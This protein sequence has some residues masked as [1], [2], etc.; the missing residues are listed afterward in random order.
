MRRRLRAFCK[1]NGL[2]LEG[3]R[4][5]WQSIF[6]N[7]RLV[8]RQFEDED[9]FLP[10]VMML[11]EAEAIGLDALCCF[12]CWCLRIEDE[13]YRTQIYTQTGRRRSRR[14][15]AAGRIVAVVSVPIDQAVR[16]YHCAVGGAAAAR[17]EKAPAN[18]RAVKFCCNQAATR[19]AQSL[20]TAVP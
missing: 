8:I 16:C 1:A 12:L 18:A 2:T 15:V 17:K 14:T 9:Y 6:D 13:T 4:D 7:G 10:D 11:L 19:R 3:E 20:R 5:E